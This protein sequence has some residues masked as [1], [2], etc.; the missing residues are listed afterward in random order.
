[1]LLFEDPIAP[2]PENIDDLFKSAVRCNDCFENG[3][4]QRSSIDLA[5]PRWIGPRYWSVRP[6]VLIVLMNPGAGGLH[7]PVVTASV[8]QL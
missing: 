5:Q 1:M 4:L 6:R 3:R 7:Q 8:Q 2:L